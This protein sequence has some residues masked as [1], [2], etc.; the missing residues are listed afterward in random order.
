MSEVEFTVRGS[1]RI[2]VPA[3]RGTIALT[4]GMEGPE[5][6][7][8]FAAVA[9]SA[10]SL[11]AD[12][13]ALHRPDSGPVT[14][15]ASERLCTGSRRPWNDAGI[16]LPL[17]YWAR[18]TFE[19]KFSDFDELNRFAARIPKFSGAELDRTTWT[20]TAKSR[21]ALE[22]K[23]RAAA[24]RDARNRAQVYA[25]ALDLGEIHPV[26]VGDPGMLVPQRGSE[27]G[28]TRFAV[29]GAPS[30]DSQIDQTPREITIEYSVEARFRTR[31]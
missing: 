22:A 19:V 29:M 25:N 27:S 4:I 12:V 7:A 5:P 28:E 20:L 2:H 21:D 10:K 9:A 14:W 1:H 23:V 26:A 31:S 24:V 17:E 30:G 13:E 6:T 18:V 11:T 16:K 8:V 15:W 3:E